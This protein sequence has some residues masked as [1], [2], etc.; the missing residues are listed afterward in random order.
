MRVGEWETYCLSPLLIR[1]I[2]GKHASDFDRIGCG[3]VGV[4]L[5]TEGQSNHASPG[6][7]DINCISSA[8][9]KARRLA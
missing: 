7:S 5:T 6:T 2:Y 9:V 3:L 4:S 1:R 8:A